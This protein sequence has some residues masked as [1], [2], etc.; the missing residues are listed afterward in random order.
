[1]KW[2]NLPRERQRLYDLLRATRAA[3]VIVLSGDRHLAELSVM[4]AQIGYPL[5]DLTSSGPNMASQRWRP[6][7]VNRHR[8]AT[9]NAGNNFGLV[10][11]DW[12]REDP[13]IRLE[14]HDEDGEVAI[15]QKVPLS[16]LQ[17]TP[18][19]VVAPDGKDLAAEALKH[20]G[21]EWTVEYT[22]V[23]VGA[24][25]TKSMYYLNSE[26][27][28]RSDANFPAVLGVKSLGKELKDL[29]DPQ[30]VYLGKKVKVTGTVTLF[31]DRPQIVVKSLDQIKV[32]E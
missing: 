1:M 24:N 21:K 23:A 6:L 8:V 29:G 11:I 13:L 30:K 25:A 26:K 7:E 18:G 2:T 19:K 10:R 31:N 9:L 28:F 27:D 15:R 14:I 3:G 22:V 4:D 32:A 20:V 12:D 5:Y 17:A 16:R